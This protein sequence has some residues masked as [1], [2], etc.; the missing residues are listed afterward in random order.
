MKSVFALA[1]FAIAAGIP[2]Q[3]SDL[4]GRI[5]REMPSLVETYKTLHAS[6]AC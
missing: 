2:A 6:P 4:D 5:D 3:P 1:A